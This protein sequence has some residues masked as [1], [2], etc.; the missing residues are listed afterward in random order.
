MFFNSTLKK[1]RSKYK[2]LY[3]E[4]FKFSSKIEESSNEEERELLKK[5]QA[6]K[7][8]EIEIFENEYACF[9]FKHYSVKKPKIVRDFTGEIYEWDEIFGNN[10]QTLSKVQ[11]ESLVCLIEEG[12]K[13]KLAT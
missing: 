13:Y 6:L 4:Y 3:F 11:K 7:E 12:G 8:K 2:E 5:Q 9:L 10:F 1:Y